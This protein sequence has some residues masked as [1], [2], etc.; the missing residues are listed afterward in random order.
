MDD[1]VYVLKDHF[2]MSEEVKNMSEEELDR[3]IA[4]LE[5]KAI[6]EGENIPRPTLLVI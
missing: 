1:I 6:E 4:I 2:E 3:R 5:E